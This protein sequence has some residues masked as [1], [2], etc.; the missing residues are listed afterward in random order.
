MRREPRRCFIRVVGVGNIMHWVGPA[1]GKVDCA[2]RRRLWSDADKLKR[3][4]TYVVSGAP[5]TCEPRQ[6]WAEAGCVVA[7]GVRDG[8]T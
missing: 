6:R 8:E 3:M 4:A 7:G 2:R 1:T 5:T